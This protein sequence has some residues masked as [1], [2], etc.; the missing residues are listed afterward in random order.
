MWALRVRERTGLTYS[1]RMLIEILLPLALRLG[2]PADRAPS[3]ID[4]VQAVVDSEPPLFD[5]DEGTT[6]TARLLVVFAWLES[7]F[8][9]DVK[10][11]G[12][13][14]IGVLQVSRYHLD[15]HE[16]D[17]VLADRRLG[18]RIGLRYM[19]ELASR[20][21]SVSR[22]LGAYASGRCGG[23]PK[24]VARRCQ[25]AGLGPNCIA[26]SSPTAG[27]STPTTPP[28]R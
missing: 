22:G 14:S 24:L 27:S 25:L 26:T 5:G 13:V 10:G 16:V 12:G 28:S 1:P 7:A 4:D 9:A 21:G 8:H 15:G 19:R 6:A 11:D 18:L 3:M 23:A 20:C 17:E 2:S